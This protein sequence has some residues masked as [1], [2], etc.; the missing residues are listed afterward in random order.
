[1]VIITQLL[2]HS[3]FISNCL[4]YLLKISNFTFNQ[5]CSFRHI[6]NSM[7][8]GDVFFAKLLV[9]PVS[10]SKLPV[11]PWSSQPVLTLGGVKLAQDFS[12]KRKCTFAVVIYFCTAILLVIAY[13]I[14][15]KS[16]L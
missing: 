15:L 5:N 11:R 14:Y 1:M 2:L 7:Q 6:L 9:K 8:E 3:H 4:S 12:Q 13:L 10:L 16:N